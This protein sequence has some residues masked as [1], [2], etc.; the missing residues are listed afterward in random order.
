MFDCRKSREED[1]KLAN[2]L[3]KACSTLDDKYILRFHEILKDV[4]S[5]ESLSIARKEILG[6][7]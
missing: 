5:V 2:Y 1:L 4:D 7:L 6:S 3:E